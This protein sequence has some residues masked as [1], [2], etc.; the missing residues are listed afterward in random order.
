[1]RF[2]IKS[3][4]LQD[5]SR[6]KAHFLIK[7]RMSCEAYHPLYVSYHLLGKGLTVNIPVKKLYQLSVHNQKPDEDIKNISN[8]SVLL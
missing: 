7:I 3:V 6:I 2:S 4:Y 1:M 5:E 8:Y